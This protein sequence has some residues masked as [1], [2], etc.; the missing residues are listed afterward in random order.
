MDRI[1]DSRLIQLTELLFDAQTLAL[2]LVG[3][4]QHLPQVNRELINVVGHVVAAHMGT[5]D[6][7]QATAVREALGAQNA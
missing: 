3:E 1:N 2:V 7:S 4:T 5:K 6:V